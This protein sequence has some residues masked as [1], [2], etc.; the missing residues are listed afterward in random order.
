MRVGGFTPNAFRNRCQAM[1]MITEGMATDRQTRWNNGSESGP[2]AKKTTVTEMRA[3]AN[4]TAQKR[5][6]GV[7]TRAHRIIGTATPS[8]PK[9]K[10][11]S[12]PECACIALSYQAYRP[13]YIPVGMSRRHL[14][15]ARRALYG[16]P[17]IKRQRLLGAWRTLSGAR[18]RAAHTRERIRL[19]RNPRGAEASSSRSR[20]EPTA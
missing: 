3:T 9:K 4:A 15:W 11:G 7:G 8:T 16:Q 14:L 19:K 5:I 10:P 20:Y 12:T 2:R 1:P 6:F 17:G 18:R 13:R